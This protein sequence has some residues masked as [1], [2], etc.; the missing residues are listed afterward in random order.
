MAEQAAD[1]ERPQG[2]RT[3]ECA[4]A[5]AWLTG[6]AELS[7]LLG[8]HLAAGRVRVPHAVAGRVE[9]VVRAHRGAGDGEGARARRGALLP[10][11][12]EEG[13]RVGG[14]GLSDQQSGGG[15]RLRDALPQGGVPPAAGHG[16]VRAARVLAPAGLLA[17]PARGP[18]QG[19]GGRAA[20]CGRGDVDARHGSAGVPC[21]VPLRPRAHVR[22][23]TV[24][25]PFCGHGTVLAV[26]N[27]LGLDAVGVE[28]S[29]KRAQ[30]AR[31]L[32]VAASGNTL[33][34]A[35]K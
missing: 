22:R 4:E 20:G 26:A 17:R 28:L 23:R 5:L 33:T 29:R 7:G 2:Q 1:A 31:S 35:P 9:A 25:D 14:Q 24:V 11:G 34:L 18:G 3:V 16:D 12:R 30:K 32:R 13:G 6:R 19:H 27:A 10:D 21:R 8:H 15:G